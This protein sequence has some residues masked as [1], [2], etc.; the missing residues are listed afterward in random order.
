MRSDTCLLFL[1]A[2]LV[3][4]VLLQVGVSRWLHAWL[5]E[6]FTPA[7]YRWLV[8]F[9]NILFLVFFGAWLFFNGD[10]LQE[11]GM[12]AAV[13]L[14]TLYMAVGLSVALITNKMFGIRFGR[15]PW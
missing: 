5:E 13:L 12:A 15:I 7:K 9:Q 8:W 4:L 14:V 10:L 3:P 11:Q 1:L 6:R 2:S